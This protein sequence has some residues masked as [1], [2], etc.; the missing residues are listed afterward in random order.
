M[1]GEGLA[2]CSTGWA[3]SA[4]NKRCSNMAS[5]E[6]DPERL[7]VTDHASRAE[8]GGGAEGEKKPTKRSDFDLEYWVS[9]LC[10]GDCSNMISSMNKCN[11]NC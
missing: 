9:V 10:C 4:V 1:E 11:T 6:A 2:C 5:S 8:T 3:R 7:G